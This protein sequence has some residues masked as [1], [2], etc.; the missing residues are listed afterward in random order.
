MSKVPDYDSGLERDSGPRKASAPLFEILVFAL[1]FSLPIALSA[2]F[3]G[4]LDES[5]PRLRRM[6]ESVLPHIGW[7]IGS[8]LAILLA[9]LAIVVGGVLG[10]NP[11]SAGIQRNFGLAAEGLV[12]S[13]VPIALT[14]VLACI[15]DP[16][17]TALA[18][19]VIIACGALV[20]LGVVLGQRIVFSQIDEMSSARRSVRVSTDTYFRLVPKSRSDRP[21]EVVTTHL[22]VVTAL[23]YG[24]TLTALGA[25]KYE[26]WL[27]EGFFL[28]L[29]AAMLLTLT[30][31][32]AIVIEQA[33]VP[34]LVS[35]MAILLAVYSFSSFAY[36]V[37]Q[38]VIE[39]ESAVALGLGVVG[40]LCLASSFWPNSRSNQVVVDVSIRGNATAIASQLTLRRIGRGLAVVRTLESQLG[41]H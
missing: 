4:E 34:S 9:F 16:S 24:A 29:L 17:Q 32:A 26:T 10:K 14:V 12:G 1:F 27:V 38:Y 35:G 40:T 20:Y 22:I 30:G 37:V 23:G 31:G 28:F 7:G 5:I 15:G 8:Y 39:G 36:L 41:A 25:W 21:W 11:R 19:L 2:L 13:F 6:G 33:A 3:D 18:M